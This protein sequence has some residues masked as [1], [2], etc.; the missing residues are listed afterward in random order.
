[1]RKDWR[2]WGVISKVLTKT[3]ATV[4]AHGMLYKSV[5]QMVLLYRSDGCVVMGAMLKLLEDFYQRVS[6]RIA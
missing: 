5:T 6:Q 4:Q 3:R 2:L 1:M